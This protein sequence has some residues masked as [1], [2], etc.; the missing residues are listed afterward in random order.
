[1]LSKAEELNTCFTL[2]LL[3]KRTAIDI[4]DV[5]MVDIHK[6]FCSV[7]TN[8]GYAGPLE[9]YIFSYIPQNNE[10]DERS[11]FDGL[12]SDCWLYKPCQTFE[13]SKWLPRTGFGLM[14]KRSNY[15]KFKL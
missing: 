7:H 15:K 5:S 14:Q 8:R 1:M 9:I 13:R 4:L 6:H 11:L 2:R 12:R 3:Q 10:S